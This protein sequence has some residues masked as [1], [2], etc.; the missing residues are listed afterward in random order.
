M[1]RAFNTSIAGKDPSRYARRI[2][3]HRPHG[4]TPRKTL[5]SFISLI[6]FLPI[7]LGP[8][9]QH[10][11]RILVN[12][13]KTLTTAWSS[14]LA[15]DALFQRTPMQ[16]THT[17]DGWYREQS[18]A[19]GTYD[20]GWRWAIGY[21]GTL[22]GD[23]GGPLLPS[24]RDRVCGVNSRFYLEFVPPFFIGMTDLISE[25]AE[26][27]SL[28]KR[29]FISNVLVDKFGHWRGDC[30]SN[31]PGLD[32]DADGF[33]DD[34]DNCP[35]VVNSDQLDSDGDGIG[36][37][38][39][40]CRFDKN[41]RIVNS[42][43]MFDPLVPHQ[44]DT[45]FIFE[46]G[47]RGPVAASPSGAGF[48]LPNPNYLT[49]DFPGDACDRTALTVPT[50]TGVAYEGNPIDPKLRLLPCVAPAVGTCEPTKLPPGMCSVSEGN[51]LA[52]T[53]FVSA[54]SSAGTCSGV[55]PAADN[56]LS[57]L[58]R[59]DFCACN[60]GESDDACRAAHHCNE[61]LNKFSGTDPEVTD[62]GW[63]AMTLANTVTNA[64]ISANGR[65]R[66]LHPDLHS[67]GGNGDEWGWRYWDDLALPPPEPLTSKNVFTGL[68]W[69]WVQTTTPGVTNV[70]FNAPPT[71]DLL[72]R[73]RSSTTRLVVDETDTG[74]RRHGCFSPPNKLALFHV[75]DISDCVMCGNGLGVVAI[76]R[77]DPA[78][79]GM[80]GP[81]GSIQQRSG[82]LTERL[83]AALADTSL[84]I[85]LASDTLSVSKGV[86]RGVLI[87]G[88]GQFRSAV[89]GTS[90]GLDLRGIGAGVGGKA[91]IPV[92]AS[93]QPFAAAV[94]G[95]RQEAA[96][97]IANTSGVQL[98]VYDF[99]LDTVVTRQLLP[100]ARPHLAQAQRSTNDLRSLGTLRTASEDREMERLVAPV[101]ATYRSQ[102]DA[103]YVLDH[104]NNE[105]VLFR[106]GV[107]LVPRSVARWTDRGH[108]SHHELTTA[109]HGELVL[110]AS[111]DAAHAIGVL[112]I[113]DNGVL[114]ARAVLKGAAPM[115]TSV[116]VSEHGLSYALER[117]GTSFPHILITE[118][119]PIVRGEV[120]GV[121]DT[122][123]VDGAVADIGAC[124]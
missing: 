83:V 5:P 66:T 56:T 112:T 49:T 19:I 64:V 60:L 13:C 63:H 68:V 16:E 95:A 20:N 58:T 2:R 119:L 87:D 118:N 8:F 116:I 108:F 110:A 32:T 22:P 45:N 3:S 59:A 1:L 26:V 122:I 88:A 47:Y 4:L 114:G 41:P 35:N 105:Y 28:E 6:Q 62:S 9:V 81:T 18:G 40:N 36:D 79:V 76:D 75:P 7:L 104:Q 101:A 113:A 55:T 74:I 69:T 80:L 115:E 120:V 23:S 97:F 72:E 44:L 39:D 103:Y 25:H 94:S 12:A 98:N 10:S 46:V 52:T 123:A 42:S 30:T 50:S 17:S 37:I 70:P 48:T 96:V 84:A 73:F 34:C 31:N 109:S 106:V 71:Q 43:K 85:V 89:I 11:F 51:T 27:D 14:A 91:G 82:V 121:D 92:P 21:A 107:E 65:V 124:F 54:T 53:S 90:G 67:A 29:T 77:G 111:S 102:D 99:D 100:S 57:G 38:C 78:N 86:G 24:T 93:P 33:P 15:H 117:V 61:I